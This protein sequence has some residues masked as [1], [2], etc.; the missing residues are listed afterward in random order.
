MLSYLVETQEQEFKESVESPLEDERILID[1]LRLTLTDMYPRGENT[2]YLFFDYGGMSIGNLFDGIFGREIVKDADMFP[3]R[4][5]IV[6]STFTSYAMKDAKE[7]FGKDLPNVFLS[8]G[9]FVT[10]YKRLN[11]LA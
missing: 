7:D 6:V 8:I 9:D 3:N 11:Q 1:G 4:T 2:D 5:Y 10:F